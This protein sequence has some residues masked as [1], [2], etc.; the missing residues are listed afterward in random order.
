V[1]AGAAVVFVMFAPAVIYALA[2]MAIGG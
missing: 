1:L 2:R